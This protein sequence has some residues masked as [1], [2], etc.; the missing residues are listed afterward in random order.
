MHI[1]RSNYYINSS[2]KILTRERINPLKGILLYQIIKELYIKVRPY[3]VYLKYIKIYSKTKIIDIYNWMIK[4]SIIDY[5]D[6]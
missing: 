3:N 1:G 2:Q 5:Q 4:W 6:R